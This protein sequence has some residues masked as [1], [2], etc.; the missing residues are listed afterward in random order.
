M[1]AELI[2]YILKGPAELDES[3]RES[4]IKLAESVINLARELKAKGD[5]VTEKDW[6]SLRLLTG[7]DVEDALDS[8]AE[9]RAEEVVRD[10]YEAWSE[11]F[12]DVNGRYDPDDGD[13]KIVVAGE[14]S[15]GDTPQGAG[16]RAFD[17]AAKL[18][19]FEHFGIR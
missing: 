7:C 6:Q 11:N 3:K 12:R 15:W 1:G 16:Y 9:M 8:L 10:V 19:L 4:A 18:G 5:D 13:Q 14:L 2:T 17:A